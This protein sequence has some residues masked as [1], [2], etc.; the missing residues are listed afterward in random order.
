MQFL[1]VDMA[2]AAAGIRETVSDLRAVADD[3]R[4]RGQAKHLYTQ[5]EYGRLAEKLIELIERV[6]AEAAPHAP[7]VELPPDVSYFTGRKEELARLHRLLTQQGRKRGPEIAAVAV[8]GKPGVGKST[9]AIH[10]AHQLAEDFPDGQLYIDLRGADNQPLSAEEALEDLL[11]RFGINGDLMPRTLGGKAAVYQRQMAGKRVLVVLDNA[12]NEQQ[13]RPMLPGASTCA[14]IVTSRQVLAVLD[15]AVMKLEVL[16]RAAAVT[17]LRRVAGASRLRGEPEAAAKVA[18]FCGCLPL[19]LRIAGAKLKRETRWTVTRLAERLADERRRL[20]ELH[21]GDLDVRASFAVSYADLTIEDARAFRLLG[22]IPGADFDPVIAAAVLGR[23]IRNY[24][25]VEEQLSRLED[26]AL[27][28]LAPGT[29]RY[30]FHDLLRLYARECLDTDEA[31]ARRAKAINEMYWTYADLAEDYEAR[32][33]PR[34]HVRVFGSNSFDL[35]DPDNTRH[36]AAFEADRGNL[37]AAVDAAY[38]AEDWGWAWRIAQRL[39]D[40]LFLY[41]YWH[42]CERAALMSVRSLDADGTWGSRERYASVMGHLCLGRIYSRQG[43][44]QAAVNWLSQDL[45]LLAQEPTIEAEILYELGNAHAAL[46]Q[47]GDAKSFYL[48]SREVYETDEE[49][50]PHAGPIAM[51]MLG[52][53]GI[54][55]AQGHWKA[56]KAYLE[57]SLEDLTADEDL[58]GQASVMLEMGNLSGDMNEW[59]HALRWYEQSL[60]RW[61][62]F[63]DEE[64]GNKSGEAATLNGIGTVYRHQARW[65]EAVAAHE[66]ALEIFRLLGM[67][68]GEAR[69][70]ANIA[71]VYADQGRESDAAVSCEHAVAILGELKSRDEEIWKQ[72]AEAGSIAAAYKVGLLLHNQ[73]PPQA[74]RWYRQAAN[75]GDL[76]AAVNLGVLLDDRDPVEAEHWCRMAADG[77]DRDGQ[78]NL[79]LLLEQDGRVEEA[80]S[81]LRKS[82]EAGSHLAQSRLAAMLADQDQ[83]TEAQ[84]WLVKAE[85]GLRTAAEA[86]DRH[87]VSSLAELLYRQERLQEAEPW[88]RKLTNAGSHQAETNLAGLLWQ[89]GKLDEAETWL[90]KAAAAGYSPAADR[91]GELLEERRAEQH[92]SALREWVSRAPDWAASGAYLAEHARVLSDPLSVELLSDECARERDDGSLWLHLG[93]L[94][95]GDHVADGYAAAETGKPSPSK[96]A[97]SHLARGNHELALA[98]S[99]LAR[100]ADSGAGALLMGQAQIHRGNVDEARE[101]LDTAVSEVSEANIGEMLAA[102]DDLLKAQSVDLIR[103]AVLLAA[104]AWPIDMGRAKEHLRDALSSPGDQLRPFPR[105]F[106][107]ALAL[108]G[109]DKPEEAIA[110][111]RAA[112][113][114]YSSQEVQFLNADRALLERFRHPPLPGVE[115]LLRSLEPL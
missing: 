115:I 13:V 26:M 72:A 55:R 10:A 1:L 89:L 85:D 29:D 11:R 12:A 76:D 71:S 43:R 35:S 57:K 70:L 40:L 56:A 108:A 83:L 54:H 102:Y 4:R 92:I 64:F 105:A 5:E 68:D 17:V 91:L 61:R 94:L 82:A 31:P 39:T 98:W 8:A 33:N 66:R 65:N 7:M 20:A 46:K 28:E 59:D 110:E 16:S 27:L 95:L 77:G 44:W 24:E 62:E 9:L 34:F 81:W 96:R 67:R 109:L 22:L 14:V 58:E 63:Q 74:E 52:L 103:A 87:A 60:A 78:Y 30:R 23:R 75:A 3:L 73:D 32:I 25:A 106:L 48:R 79:A 50:G 93:L 6:A 51:I 97:V 49:G 104:I 2:S 88:F 107:R 45:V 36:F 101:A 111:L 113:E 38:D 69:A 18:E 41:G 21:E 90:R 86:G 53:G 100:A 37:M 19:A 84:E 15:A 47:W 99:C 114:S 80:E 42:D 112:V